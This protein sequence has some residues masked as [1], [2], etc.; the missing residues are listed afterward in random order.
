MKKL[1]IFDFDGT[2]FDSLTDV[3]KCF[4][5]TFEKLGLDTFDREFYK[6]S[7]GGNMD[8]I[9]SKL[10]QDKNTPVN[11]TK[12]KDT[13]AKIYDAD[14]KENTCLFEGM[15]DVLE[16]LQEEGMILAINSNRS[17]ESIKEFVN[18]FA[19]N[20]NFIDIQGPIPTEASKPD[21]YG[22]NTIIK[23]AEMSKEDCVYIGD[24]I[25]DI[26][27]AKNAGIDCIL[28]TWGYGIDDVY[29]NEYPIAIVNNKEELMNSIKNI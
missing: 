13:Y 11:M 8:Q 9:V 22:V 29:E 23:K 4:N 19:D 15:L 24:S 12:V 7:V 27:T 6:R 20:I 2:L 1:C 16:Q 18:K 17:A 10:L 25:T 14:L 3:V 21:P 28:V 5:K 26:L